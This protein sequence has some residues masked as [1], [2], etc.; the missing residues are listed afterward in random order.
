[1]GRHDIIAKLTYRGTIKGRSK[2]CRILSLVTQPREMTWLEIDAIYYC[3]L[4][5][6]YAVHPVRFRHGIVTMKGTSCYGRSR[7]RNNSRT[8][9][10]NN[11]VL[12][13]TDQLATGLITRPFGDVFNKRVINIQ[14]DYVAAPRR[15]VKCLLSRE[16][17]NVTY[18][19]CSLSLSLSL[20]LRLTLDVSRCSM[21]SNAI[22]QG[23]VC[24]SKKVRL[25]S[26]S[27]VI[28]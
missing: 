20:S 18:T 19:R 26:S 23:T 14:R 24:N 15:R 27:L 4:S 28:T 17:C 16:A 25:S 12:R 8:W 21:L 1:M 3:I 2:H 5:V 6:F 10:T 7:I 22:L 9:S 11:F 13:T